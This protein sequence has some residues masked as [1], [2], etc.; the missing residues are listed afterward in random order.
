MAY[1]DK[2]VS[3]DIERKAINDW[4]EED[5]VRGG[6]YYGSSLVKDEYY[7]VHTL[8]DYQSLS[9]SWKSLVPEEYVEELARNE[10]IN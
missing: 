5:D 4:A 8:E 1:I 7:F 3:W 2:V 6:Y 10:S 9:E